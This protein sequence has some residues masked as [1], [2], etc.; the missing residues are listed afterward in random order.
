MGLIME[1]NEYYKMFEFENDYWWYRGLHELVLYYVDRFKRSRAPE[2]LR[3]FDAGCGTGRLMEMM[4]DYGAVEG[5][6]YSAD[7]VSLCKERGLKCVEIG[8]LNTWNPPAESWDIIVSNDVICTSGVEDDLA[9]IETFYRALKKGGI[10]ILNLPAFDVLRRRHDVAVYGKRRYR[11]KKTLK[12][13]EK[14]GFTAVRAAYRLPLLFFIILL[15]KYLL[16]PFKKGKIE[17]DLKKLPPFL[18][19]LLLKM[20]RIENKLTT[21]G[22]SFP[23]GSSLFLVCKK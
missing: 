18:N 4:N 17:S 10:L 8:D 9:V 14:L 22:I 6:D 13:M 3:I 2:E 12:Q 20:N 7:A 21:I 19:N 15:Q 16:E 1:T 11:K 23:F 5:I